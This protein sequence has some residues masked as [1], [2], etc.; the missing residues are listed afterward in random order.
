MIDFAVERPAREHQVN[1]L[2]QPERRLSIGNPELDII[3]NG[4]LTRDRLYLVEGTPGTGK[5][6]LAMQ[7]VREGARRGEKTLYVTLGE[8]R[9]EL[10]ATA[11]SHGWELDGVD[12][13]ELV[14]LEAQLDRQQ[15]VLQPSEVELGETMQ[16]VCERIHAVAP[17][18]L[19]IDSLSELR[20]LAR[21]PLRFRRQILALKAFLSGRR[22]TTLIL[23]D[24]TA[25]PVGLQLHSIVH[26]V[27][28]LE[29]LHREFGA[30]R[31]RLRISKMRGSDVQSGYH[32]FLIAPGRFTVFPSLIADAAPAET[33]PENVSSDLPELD[34]LL[35][36]GLTRGTATMLMGPIGRGQDI[37]RGAIR[38]GGDKPRR[39]RGVFCFRRNLDDVLQPRRPA[40][41]RCATRRLQRP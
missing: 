6:T 23:D 30:V 26:G 14:P 22:C 18:R 34:A 20:L 11:T 27:F 38:D 7:F 1:D 40:R 31:R 2:A 3:I 37:A 21:D 16:L 5:T 28:T 24:L 4:G 25:S 32:D 15:T 13:Y 19:V 12:I 9:E 29:Q 36:G 10:V 8:T 33:R 35:G 17:D 39:A 41:L